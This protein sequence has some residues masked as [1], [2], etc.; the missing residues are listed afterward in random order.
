VTRNPTELRTRIIQQARQSFAA[1]GYSSTTLDALA[2]AADCSVRQLKAHFPTKAAVAAALL[3]D[4]TGETVTAMAALTAG[5][6]AKRYHALLLDKMAQLVPYRGAVAAVFS[7]ALQ[8]DQQPEAGQGVGLTETQLELRAA[9]ETLVTTA[10]DAPRLPAQSSELAQ[11]LYT[12]HLLV[13]LFWLYDR[14][15][16]GRAT[17]HLIDL[18]RDGLALAR[19]AL[20]LPP[21]AKAL[22]RLTATLSAG[23]GL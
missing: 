14:S 7:A 23:F 19:P 22:T 3:D 11:L 20:V 15:A 5:T 6:F 1:G 17:R 10:A 2:A 9:F 21:V 16:E 13:I 4:L 8:P 12:G 18:I